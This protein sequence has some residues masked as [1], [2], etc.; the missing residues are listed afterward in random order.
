MTPLQWAVG[1][2]H[3]NIVEILLK[4]K[5]NLNLMDKVIFIN[6]IEDV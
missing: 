2:G 1:C 4:A 3:E 6:Y 5:P